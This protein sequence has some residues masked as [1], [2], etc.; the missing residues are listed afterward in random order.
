MTRGP[1]E[2][3]GTPE[4]PI[5]DADEDAEIAE[6][7]EE[8]QA[9]AFGT[10]ALAEELPGV[11][12]ALLEAKRGIEETLQQQATRAAEV[13]ALAVD[14]FQ[15]AGQI[16]GVA[17]GLAEEGGLPDREPVGPPG[18]P[19]LTVYTAE[20]VPPEH[21]RS[22]VVDRMGVQA[23]AAEDEIPLNVVPTGVIDAFP[24]R[25]RLRPAPGGISVGH[26]RIT[27]G[28]LGC[29]SF[30]R[31]APRNAR[32]LILS[33]NHV[34]ANSNDARFGDC[35]C[36]PGPVD[37]GAC[38]A[39]QVA[40][41]ERFVP[42]VFGGAANFVDCATAWAWPDRVRRELLFLS[43]GVPRFFGVSNAPVAPALG[44]S[45]GKTGRTTQVTSGRITAIGAS[46]SV[47]YAG[48]IAFFRDQLAIQAF[49]G[50]FSRGGDSG[51][52]IWTWNARRNP[53]GLL[54]AGGGGVTFAN[55]ID[56]VLTALDISLWT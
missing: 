43:G 36:Q 28:T 1:S 2:P 30:G 35:V 53:V 25:F 37:G 54:F 4:D 52:L 41:L 10:D 24:H 22:L 15:E 19:T 39:D 14:T 40:I 26:F 17:I 29:L 47:N 44:M 48:R 5:E 46:I 27:A 18:T 12:P 33:N 45:V 38:P 55:R 32:A 42:I 50:D 51:S 56:R 8:A 31:S 16:Q 11:P 49:S 21:V 3:E 23:A 34:V 13:G 7:I 20:P 9:E 6:P